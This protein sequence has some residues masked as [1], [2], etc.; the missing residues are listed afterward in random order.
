[1]AL[2]FYRYEDTSD[3]D[4]RWLLKA[5]TGSHNHNYCSM[6]HEVDYYCHSSDKIFEY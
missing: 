5:F 1:L 6:L 4:W 2:K 3:Y